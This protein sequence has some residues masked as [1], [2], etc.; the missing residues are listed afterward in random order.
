MPSYR[1]IVRGENFL[2]A[3]DGKRERVGFYQTVFVRAADPESAEITATRIVRE[4]PELNQITLN[5]ADPTLR[6]TLDTIEEISDAR[7]PAVQPKG[8]SFFGS[9]KWW[10]FWRKH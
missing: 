1:A 9:R 2:V 4:D 8:R 3:F 7:F 5:F 10:Q 6:L